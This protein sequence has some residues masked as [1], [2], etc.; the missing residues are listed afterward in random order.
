MGICLQAAIAALMLYVKSAQMAESYW[1]V[2]VKMG[3]LGMDSYVEVSEHIHCIKV[4]VCIK[5]HKHND[6]YLSDIDECITGQHDCNVHAM[7]N[8][9]PGKYECNCRGGYFGNETLCIG[10][11]SAYHTVAPKFYV[12]TIQ[13]NP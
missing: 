10:E 1:A 2:S 13:P 11:F 9:T 4:Q 5:C 7:C 12:Y 3:S 6:A 8:N